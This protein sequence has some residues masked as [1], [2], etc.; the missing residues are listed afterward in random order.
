MAG[1]IAFAVNAILNQPFDSILAGIPVRQE[2]NDALRDRAGLYRQ[3][4]ELAIA[5]ERANG[6]KLGEMAV[7]LK[8]DEEKAS[9]LCVSA[10]NWTAE[11]G[12]VRT[13]AVR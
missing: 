7:E 1:S 11:N 2:I 5:H 10:V 12:G 6:E 9:A 8:I 3:L 4:F 13:P